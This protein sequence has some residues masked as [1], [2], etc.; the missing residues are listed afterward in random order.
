M[1]L[2]A[3]TRLGPYELQELIGAGGMG[4]VYRAHDPRIRRDVAIKI[5]PSSYATD[6]ERLERFRREARAAGGLNHPNILTVYDVGTE[7]GQ[8]YIVSELLDGESL[9]Q[10]IQ[11]GPV[12]AKHAIEWAAQLAR[13][14]AAAHERGIVHR[15]L[16]PENVF[17]TRDGRV[18]VLDFGI[19]GVVALSQSAATRLET[20]V[21]SPGMLIG[22]VGYM[23]PEQA[24]GAQ[25]DARSDIFALGVVLHEML[26]GRQPFARPTTVET[27]AASLASEAPPLDPNVAPPA[28]ARIVQRMMA[29]DP[30]ERFQSARDVAFL[31]EELDAGAS[32]AAAAR[33]PGRGVAW[34]LVAAACVA[35]LAAALGLL[36]G[37]DAP[38]PTY[39]HLTSRRG[40]V[41]SARF[42]PDG[43]TIAYSASWDGEPVE[44]FSSRIGSLQARSLG[45]PPAALVSMSRSGE[46]ALLLN[47]RWIL[48]HLRV[49][50]LARA[51][52]AGG[53]LREVA[54][55][56]HGADWS[57]DGR[58]LAIVR[59]V[60]GEHRL[61]FPIGRVLYG[62]HGATLHSPRVSPDGQRVALFERSSDTTRLITV[63]TTGERRVLSEGW[64]ITSRGLAWRPD[65]DEVWFTAGQTRALGLHAASARRGERVLLKLPKGLELFDVA[66]DGRVLVG[67]MFQHQLM[68]SRRFAT[69]TDQITSSTDLNSFLHDISNDGS[70]VLYR[71]FDGLRL[72]RSDDSSPVLLAHEDRWIPWSALAPDG[73]AVLVVLPPSPEGV[74]TLVPTGTGET[75]L[76]PELGHV[77]WADWL[78][79]SR[80]FLFARNRRDGITI[81]V[82]DLA[83]NRHREIRNTNE[84]LPSGVDPAVAADSFRLSSDGRRLAIQSSRGIQIYAIDDGAVEVVPGTN[85]GYTMIGWAGDGQAIYVYRIGDIPVVVSRLELETGAVRPF[86]TLGSIDRAGLWR[87]HPVRVTP[88]GRSYTYSSSHLL[89]DLYLIEGV[90]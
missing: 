9:R 46:M 3:G 48:T 11:R 90:R 79:D 44:L 4:E 53:A 42:A 8:P 54:S 25:P 14:L 10:V 16:K 12:P 85:A 56:V 87:I 32:T 72:K 71:D 69:S 28:A 78:P 6:G 68:Y 7:P 84:A 23:A 89:S 20:L 77:T 73:M 47:P 39:Q 60:D 13:A 15:D 76:F 45:F 27:L 33:R 29:R 30:T 43:Q 18:K 5:L 80:R 40:T 59:A 34:I 58:E 81:G 65:G 63:S 66:S 37:R 70:V 17:V 31:L 1:A 26:A 19:A 52:L 83:S 82:F 41:W 50:T 75:R 35:A 57:P 61:E 64:D 74:L 49:G 67:H 51:D 55:G 88:D 86:M 21:T 62:T 24:T 36:P 22:T 2:A 38:P